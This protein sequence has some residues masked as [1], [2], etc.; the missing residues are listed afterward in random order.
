M[1]RFR[2]L[3][4]LL[5]IPLISFTIHK[6]Y[7][8]LC[9]I[10]YVED[11]KAI[12]IKL[13]LFIDDIELTLNKNHNSK[14]YLATDTEVENVDELYEEYLSNHFSLK[15]NNEDV[16]FTYL[17]KEYD[18]DIVRFYIE[19]LDVETLK[20]LEVKNTCLFKDFPDQQNIIKI[21]V[22]KLH[23]TFYFDKKN[24]KGLLKF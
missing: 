5:F 19:V 4:L 3:F 18:D 15:V 10:E 7:I 14:L 1:K 24:D 12:Q 23:K 22:N 20:S 6:Y 16:S 8:S 13:G 17:G 21:K 11:Q 2:F 9:E